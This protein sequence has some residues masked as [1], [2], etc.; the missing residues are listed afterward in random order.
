MILTLSPYRFTQDN[1]TTGALV[2]SYGVQESHEIRENQPNTALLCLILALGTFFIAYYLRQFRNS[3]FLG[4]SV[5]ITQSINYYN[6]IDTFMDVLIF[7]CYAFCLLSFIPISG[8]IMWGLLLPF[9]VKVH[10]SMQLLQ[11]GSM[12][13]IGMFM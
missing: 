11:I 7:C 13:Y 10:F 4:R 6:K 8:Y 12:T 5:S 1:G 2:S 9:I 3:N